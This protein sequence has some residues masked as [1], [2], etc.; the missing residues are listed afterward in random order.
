MAVSDEL[1]S[2]VKEAE[3]LRTV[4][5]RDTLGNWTVGYGHKLI[6]G[7]DWSGYAINTDTA[8]ALLITDLNQATLEA[9]RLMEWPFLDTPARKDAQVELVYNMGA[10]RW[11]T[12][13]ETRFA[14]RAHDWQEAHDQ[15]LNSL[16]ATQVGRS[17]STRLANQLLYGVYPEVT[18]QA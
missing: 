6:K 2:A 4:A 11:V 15:L 16:W 9:I 17:R 1:L 8:S 10:G 12:F 18:I 3:G 14:I 7:K 5:Y 13:T